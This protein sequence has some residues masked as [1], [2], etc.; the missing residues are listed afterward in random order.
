V[1]AGRRQEKLEK[2]ADA[3]RPFG[4]PVIPV[5]TDI[6]KMDDIESLVQRTIESFGKIDFLFNNAGTNRRF[7]SEDYTEQD[8][9]VVVNTNLKGPFFLS[10]KV[11]KVMIAQQRKGA[12]VNIASLLGVSG[13][14]RVPAYAASKG[15]VIQ[16]TRPMANDWAKYN[17]RVNALGPGWVKTELTEPYHQNEVRY[18]EITSRIAMGRWA[19]PEDLVGTAIFLVSDASDYITGQT[20]FVDGGWLS[21]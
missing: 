6:L 4:G 10:Q 16:I 17:I 13:G 19:E 9:D 20:L 18:A 12:I 14:H 21:M 15:G 3:I 5:P 8:W 1:I 7:S 2:A 11:A